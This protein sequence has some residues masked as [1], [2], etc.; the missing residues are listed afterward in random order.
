MDEAKQ[1][2]SLLRIHCIP[3]A[4]IV[5]L[6]LSHST[7]CLTQIKLSDFNDYK[8][9][10]DED[11]LASTYI[12]DIEEDKFGFLWLATGNGISRYDGNHFTNF[13]FYY[14]GT[15]ANKIGFVTSLVID[16]SGENLWIGCKDGI[17]HT[18]VDSVNLKK[19]NKV[20]PS[21]KLSIERTNDLL[22]D[23]Q[24]KLWSASTDDGIYCYDVWGDQDE[25]FSFKGDSKENNSKLNSLQCIVKDPLDSNILWIGTGAGLVR[26]NIDSKDYQV[27]VYNNNAEMAQNHIRKIYASENDVYIGT[28]V[29]GLV[30]FNKQTKQFSQPIKDR[31]LNSHNLILNFY[32]EK[33]ANLWISTN[34]GLIQYDVQSNTI[35]KVIDHNMEKGIMRGV[36]FIDTKGIL[37]FYSGKGLFKYDPLKSQNTFI[38]L[39]KCIGIQYPMLVRDIIIAKGYYYVLGHHSSGLYKINS[40]DHTFEV[41]DYPYLKSGEG[42]NINLRKMVKM[43][44]GNFLILSSQEI[45]IFNPETQQ[46]KLSSLQIDHPYPSMQA[47]VKDKNNNYWIGSRAAGLFRLNFENN[48]IKNYKEEFDEF[49]DGNYRWIN[50]LYI[51]SKNKLWIGKGSSSVMDLDELSIF[52]IN[53]K[54]KKSILAYQDVFDFYEDNT[55]R[56]WMAGGLDGLGY[57]NFDNFKKGVSNKADGYFSGVYPYN[58]TLLWISGRNLGTFNT[59]T[60]SYQ[61]IKLSANNKRL[62]VSGPIIS[63]GGNEYIIGCDN[64]ILIY[65]PEKQIMNSEIPIPYIRKI[66]KDGKTIYQ[67]NSLTKN[68]FKFNSGTEHLVFKMSSLGFH[69]SDQITYQ[70]RFEGEW[71]NIGAANEIYLMNLSHGDYKLEIKACN[72][73]GLCNEIPK[74]YNITILTPWWATWWAFIIYFV[75]VVLLADRFYRFQL[76]KRLVIAESQRLTE[77]NQLKNSLYAN[78]THEFRTP[79]TVILGMADS[80]R[81]D[82]EN[83]QF[84]EAEHSLEMINRNSNNLLRLVNEILDLSKLESGNMKLQLIQTDVIPFV[85]YLVESFQTLA[86]DNQIDLTVYSEIDE[87]LMDIDTNKLSVIISNV[88]SNAIKFTQPGGKI[89]VHFNQILKNKNE[90]LIINVKDTGLGI[91]EEEIN[92]IFNRFYQV[93]NS[94]TRRGTGTGIGLA[95]TKELVELMNGYIGVKS[96]SGKGS[97]FTIHL[98]ISNNAIQKQNV[99]IPLDPNLTSTTIREEKIQTISDDKSELPLALIIEDNADVVHYLKTCLDG[100]YQIIHA[101]DGN[102]GIETALEKVPDIIVCDVLMPGKDGFEVCS[103]LKSDERTDHIP[104]VLLTAKAAFKDRLTGLSCGADAYLIKPFVKAELLTR[105]DQLVLLRKKIMQKIDNDSFSHL[106]KSR[107]ENHETKF[108]QKII[109][110]IHKE[111]SNHSFGS[112]I[113]LSR[114]MQLSESQIYRK[115]KAITGKSTAVFIRSVRLQK[116]KELLQTTDKTIS[117]TAYYVGFDDPSWFSRAFKEEF[118]F[119]PSAISK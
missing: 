29:A 48:T 46:I 40:T 97:K 20:N 119:S 33:N 53:P 55:G 52:C 64:G 111:I 75:I 65:N 77:V 66:E 1:I 6:L 101:K 103:E 71:Q 18:S 87:L 35:T 72:N 76:S 44:N 21:I 92:N 61:E 96:M 69:F 118:G 28:W 19:I 11:G 24:K 47:L 67:G 56:V 74:E 42:H 60:M 58:D 62:R 27:S 93:D 15:L 50:T 45:T 2:L 32:K 25:K 82:V 3:S 39:E 84:K 63:A 102:I 38:E 81:S 43:D 41:I 88:L 30:V 26:F 54:D 116:A 13:I 100:K 95:M 12:S 23:K 89:I 51:D 22:L 80:L 36:S 108:L 117:E 79:L 98:P 78:I 114:K 49:R 70:Y 37:W 99:Q 104:I 112:T 106:L 90:F 83:K 85:R 86:E 73:L 91:P 8:H 107:A 17:F 115:L 110:I 4:I 9:Y 109:K 10:T 7:I 113:H 34:H 94:S 31:F 5:L 105:L 14:E 68:N 57:T 16:E 59:N